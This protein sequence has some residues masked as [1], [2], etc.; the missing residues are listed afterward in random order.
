MTAQAHL[1]PYAPPR[2][3][4]D[5]VRN[6]A[7]PS[8]RRI[9][10][11][12]VF[13]LEV[14]TLGLYAPYW[15]YTR[16]RIWNSRQPSQRM[17]AAVP[18]V[19]MVLSLVSLPAALAA[20]IYADHLGLQTLSAGAQLGSKLVILITAF[21]FRSVMNRQYP[22]RGSPYWVNGLLTFFLLVLYLNYKLNQR[23]DSGNLGTPRPLP[24][25]EATDPSP[26]AT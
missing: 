21:N 4:V 19:A 1:N 20:G 24:A 23:L 3:P 26:S 15:L 5:D 6:A 17:E 7:D 14:V 25:R 8:F 9:N 12:S 18:M 22:G 10:T 11:W 13:L 16:S 2:A